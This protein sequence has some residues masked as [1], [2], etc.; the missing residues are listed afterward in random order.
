VDGFYLIR[1]RYYQG[2]Q[3]RRELFANEAPYEET[4]LLHLGVNSFSYLSKTYRYIEF[5]DVKSHPAEYIPPS[6]EDLPSMRFHFRDQPGSGPYW[7]YRWDDEVDRNDRFAN[8]RYYRQRVSVPQSRYG[9]TWRAIERT[10]FDRDLGVAGM[11]VLVVDLLSGEVNAVRRGFSRALMGRPTPFHGHTG[12]IWGRDLQCP[13]K[14]GPGRPGSAAT[15]R[16]FLTR[17][18]RPSPLPS[19]RTKGE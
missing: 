5:P 6:D 18:L 1:P 10:G 16:E 11:E 14:S 2:D 3:I 19:Q 4:G 13:G 8:P 15:F 9:I 12:N 17:V 7:H